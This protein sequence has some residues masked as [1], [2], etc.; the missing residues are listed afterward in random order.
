MKFV[1]FGSPEFAAIVL[2]KMI[3]GG[4]KPD[5]VICNP[6]RPFGRKKILTPP[7]T[8]VLAKEF[9]IAVWQPE[10]LDVES[11]EKKVGKI[12]FAVV[13]AYAKIIPQKTVDYPRLGTIGVHPSLLP[14]Y[15][16]ASPIQNA[17]LNGEKETGMS[18]YLMDEKVDHGPI[19]AQRRTLIGA[20]E[21]YLQLERRLAEMAGDLLAVTLPDFYAG[22][23]K[24]KVQDASKMIMTG[25]FVTQDA[26]IDPKDLEAAQGGDAKKSLEIHRK[27]RAFLFEP[28][29][30]TKMEGRR[31][32]ILETDIRGDSLVLKKIQKEGEKPKLV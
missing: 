12:D 4:C 9:K 27:V 20:H 1:F 24:P 21:N 2:R 28:G 25:K 10:K 18:L 30:W 7:P 23:I 16:G 31:I 3:E 17:I 11:F 6:D 32:K 22:D 8:K 29:A 26:F 5:L 14:K 19:L 15:R 13:A